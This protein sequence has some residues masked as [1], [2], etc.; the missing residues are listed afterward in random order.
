MHRF[1]IFLAVVAIFCSGCSRPQEK[2]MQ[3][4]LDTYL[5]KIV[6]L[7]KQAALAYWDAATTGEPEKFDEYSNLD[8]QMRTIHSDTA[9][10]ALLKRLKES[11]QVKDAE[12]ARQLDLVYNNYLTNQIDPDLLKAIVE[13]TSKVEK[14]FSTFRSKIDGETAT[15]NEIETILK[16]ETDS[17]KRQ[18]A[19]LASKQVA[20]VIAEDV[21]ELA[22]LRNQAAQQ[23]GF[24]NYHTMSLVSTEYNPAELD[25][26]FDELYELTNEPFAALKQ[27]LDGILADMYGIGVK[28]MM[29]WHY[30]DPFFQESPQVYELDLDKYYANKDVVELSKAYYAGIGMPVEAILA[31]SDLYEREGKNP[32]AFCTDIDR[33]G[34]VR[35]LC[36]IQNNERWMETQL[37]ELGHAVYDFYHDPSTPYLLREPAHMFT[38]EAIAMFFG[39]LSRNA[40][41][42]QDMLDLTDAERQDIA[43]V[44]DK[45]ARLKQLV[46]ARWAMVMYSFEKELYADPDQDL[47]ALWW[48]LVEKYQFV[49]KPAGRDEPDWAAKIHV[50]LYP[51]YYHNYMLGEL[52]ASQLHHHI[53]Y[54]V[55]ELESAEGVSYVGNKKLGH[56]LKTEIFAPGSTR[57]WN[58]MIEQATGEPLTAKYFVEQFVN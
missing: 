34:D 44:A 43:A 23:L 39:R 9:D 4:F 2:E 28:G 21:V 26:I 54:D 37:H 24:E 12:L 27:E 19:W 52:L 46:F 51:V 40:D 56:Y 16:N 31:N 55:L 11:G 29:P 18:K 15:N 30:H 53:I 50:A 5:E 45:Y 32:H 20:L 49:K 41:W 36:N 42:M 25:A 48:N 57:P 13:K 38:T 1:V 22:K 33:Q 10:F 3:A 7:E 8:L 35:I 14:K 6:P 47:N 17:K 58:G